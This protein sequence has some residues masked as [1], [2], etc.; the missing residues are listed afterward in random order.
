MGT[1]LLTRNRGAIGRTAMNEGKMEANNGPW[2]FLSIYAAES[3]KAV[4]D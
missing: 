4:E 2:P 1:V 3:D